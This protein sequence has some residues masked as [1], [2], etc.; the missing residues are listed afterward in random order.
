MRRCPVCKKRT[1]T[2]DDIDGTVV[3]DYCKE[4]HYEWIDTRE[5]S[6]SMRVGEKYMSHIYE[7]TIRQCRV[8]NMIT[9][10]WVRQERKRYNKSK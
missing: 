5:E 7:G 6:M 4:G 1:G 9:A 8:Q 10:R 2:Y 3:G